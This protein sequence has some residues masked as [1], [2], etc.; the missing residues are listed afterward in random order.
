MKKV[1][2]VGVGTVGCISASKLSKEKI[3]LKIIDRDFVEPSNVGVQILYRKE[4]V[5]IPKA[6][7]AK[8]RLEK[9]GFKI[10]ATVDDLNRKNVDFLKN[11]DMVLDGTDNFD[12]RFLINDYCRKEGIPWVYSGAIKN[13][14]S[15]FPVSPEGPCFQ[16]V[17]DKSYSSETCDTAGV[18]G[19]VA[20][21]VG[22]LQ[23]ELCMKILK[24]NLENSNEMIRFNSEKTFRIRV[25]KRLQCRACN[26][27]YDYLSGR[28]GARIVKMC[29]S[30]LYQ[31]KGRSVDF[32]K[33]MQD[34]REAKNF[35]SCIHLDG[36]T[37]F[38]D[39]RALI[40]ADSATQAKSIYFKL[41]G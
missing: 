28:K 31:I 3:S 5:G 22:L 25:K 4:D 40:K 32:S 26:G 16:C 33:L 41:F 1:V 10:D 9:Q 36:V 19:D 12:A 39:G 17:F 13:L 24:G 38:K 15:C 2:L 8:K 34:F 6:T 21:G 20:L 7:A 35:G 18:S 27:Q 23:A 37:V 30:N 14:G 29:G 11:S